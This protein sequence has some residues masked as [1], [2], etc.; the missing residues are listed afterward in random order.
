MREKFSVFRK[1]RKWQKRERVEAFL[2]STFVNGVFHLV[3]VAGKA[4]PSIRQSNFSQQHSK[5]CLMEALDEFGFLVLFRC[6]L[7]TRVR[8]SMAFQGP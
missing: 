1:E 6:G 2:M 3:P 7:P 4:R 5:C 8:L